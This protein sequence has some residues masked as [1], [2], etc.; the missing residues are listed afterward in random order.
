MN[1]N[2]KN[3]SK[4]VVL[5][6]CIASI[7]VLVATGFLTFQKH[8]QQDAALPSVSQPIINLSEPTSEKN[9]NLL[10]ES[11]KS[12]ICTWTNPTGGL[13]GNVPQQGRVYIKNNN[14]YGEI[15]SNW[16]NTKEIQYI[17]YDDIY[18]YSWFPEEKPAF[19]SSRADHIKSQ[20]RY[21]QD[22]MGRFN[23]STYTYSC[24]QINASEINGELFI[25]PQ[26]IRF[27]ELNLNS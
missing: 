22:M 2:P 15:T 10:V 26:N 12:F 19:I 3:G 14:L 1:K 13:N 27:E 21:G 6:L 8:R 17:L 4:L 9:I 7:F 16:E 20:Q 24:N 18:R 5:V 23:D 11:G 25:K